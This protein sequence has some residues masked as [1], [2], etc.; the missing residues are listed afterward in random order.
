[1]QTFHHAGI[2][3]LM[4][5]FCASHNNTMGI[6]VTV[7]NSFIHTIMYSYYTG[8]ALGWKFLKFLKPFIT[9]AQL[10]QF[11]GGILYSTPT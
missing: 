7:L 11:I 10:T 4:W 6:C 3:I 1:M 8:S 2:V 5:S 9:S